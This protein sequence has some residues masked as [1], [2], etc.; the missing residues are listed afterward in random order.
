M[1]VGIKIHS[2]SIFNS[3]TSVRPSV[4][5][6]LKAMISNPSD[7]FSHLRGQHPDPVISVI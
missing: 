1:Y 6:D 3:T 2:E 7:V 5:F 4:S